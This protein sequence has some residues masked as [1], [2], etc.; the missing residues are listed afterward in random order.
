MHITDSLEH[1]KLTAFKSNDELLASGQK[2]ALVWCG[3][4]T[5]LDVSGEMRKNVSVEESRPGPMV[6]GYFY[7]CRISKVTATVDGL[8]RCG[9]DCGSRT[10]DI[11]IIMKNRAPGFQLRG[12]LLPVSA[13]AQTSPL[14][15]TRCSSR[16]FQKNRP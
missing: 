5:P 11:V 8:G 1:H 6:P 10:A 9:I 15:A 4:K 7:A 3:T 14:L 2:M 12:F 13:T 16:L